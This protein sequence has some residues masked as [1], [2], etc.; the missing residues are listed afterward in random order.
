MTTA[1]G[2]VVWVDSDDRWHA[3]VPVTPRAAHVARAAI[4]AAWKA[5]GTVPPRRPVILTRDG[6]ASGSLCTR[7]VYVT[8]H[9]DGVTR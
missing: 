8:V 5:D 4:R 6:Y 3:S 9:P 7:V 1:P 2:P